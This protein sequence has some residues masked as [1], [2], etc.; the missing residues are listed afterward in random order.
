MSKFCE[1]TYEEA[2]IHLL[3]ENG[4]EYTCGDDLHRK[5]DET[6]IEDD[7]RDYLSRKYAAEALEDEEI[8]AI[9]ANLRNTGDTSDYLTLRKVFSLY[10]GRGDGFVF[11]RFDGNDTAL[12]IDYIDFETPENNTFRVVN[13]FTVT[14]KGGT[15]ERRPDVLLF[16]NGIPVCIV[17]LKNPAKVSATIEDAYDQIHIRYKRD[18]PHLMK[19]CALSCISDASNTRLGTTY[20]EYIHY[21]AW[22]KVENED[23][24]ANKGVPQLETLIKG[25]YRPDRL[26]QILRDFVY[27]PDVSSGREEEVVCRYPQFFATNLLSASIVKHLRSRG[28]DGKGGTYFGA[29]GCGKTYTMLFLSRY[30]ALREDS[31]GSPTIVILVDREDLQDQ[32]SKL[33]MR[34]AE[35]LSNGEVREIESRADLANELKVRESGGVFICTI[36]KF[37]EGT[38]LVNERSNIICFSDEAHRSQLGVGSKLQ[39][40]DETGGARSGATVVGE[41]KHVPNREIGAYV[42]YGFAKYLRDAFPN[43]TYVGFSG[44]PID[45]TIHVFG[46]IVDRY[47]MRQAVADDVTVGIKYIPRLARVILDKEKAKEIEYYYRLCADEGAKP[48][49]IADS[50]EAMASLEVI[51]SDEGRIKRLVN[52]I[53]EHYEAMCADNP[54]LIQK[55]MVVCASRPIA[56]QVYEEF[57]AIRPAWFKPEGYHDDGRVTD[58][59]KEKLK[60]MPFI[61]LVGT[62][63]KDDPQAMYEAFGDKKHR[64][65]LAEQFKLEHSNFRIAVVVDMWITG[66]DVPNLCVMYN[67]KPLQKQSLI[68]TI[69]RVNRKYQVSKEVKKEYGLIVDYI[70]IYENMREAMKKYGGDAEATSADEVET[71][72]AIFDAELS[73]LKEMMEGC[74]MSDFFGDDPLKRLLALQRGAEYVLAMPKIEGEKVSFQTRFKGH[75]RR[76]K[77][78]YDICHPAGALGKD[79]IEWAQMLLAIG[80]FIRKASD[81]EHD[82]ASM[83]RHVEQMV[84]EAIACTGV[85]SLLDTSKDAELIFSE[86]FEERLKEVKLPNTKFQMLVKMMKRAIRE[87]SMTNK[88]AAKRFDDML[89]EIVK[90]YNNRDSNVFANKVAGEVHEAVMK[91]VE[92]KV[93]SLSERIIE[94]FRELKTDKEKFK[95]LGITFEEKAFY[96]ILVSVR[97]DNGFEYANEKCL[98][99][100]K[101]IK[102]LIDD[103]AI[104]ADWKNN[105]NLRNQLNVDI[106]DLLYANGYPPEWH[107]KVYDRVMEQVDNFKRHESESDDG[108][109]GATALPDGGR[110]GARPSREILAAVAEALRFR[111]YLPVYTLRAAC[112]Y[113]GEGEPVEPEGWVKVENCGRLDEGMFVVRAKGRSMEP[114]IH[115]GDLCVMR[116]Y[117][118]GSRNGEIVLAQH[119]EFYDSDSG[120]AYSIKKYSSEKVMEEDGSW[121][122]ERITLSPLNRD[123]EPIVIDAN[124]D[125]EFAVVGVLKG[126]L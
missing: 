78:A 122:H 69:S 43:A 107:D 55:A 87:Y 83:N 117:E 45:E 109:R 36:Q 56:Y 15:K 79:N 68:Q 3:E 123:Y 71:A 47:T 51:L 4:W 14:Y 74:D 64:E 1:S 49:D 102:A 18:I 22:K 29:T 58:K 92:S 11:K 93:E 9:V 97:D 100:A 66:F 8:G 30:L 121:H 27:F 81:S 54:L 37:S 31:V 96:D 113:F 10:C 114:K 44:T 7:L 2:F 73:A 118:G 60:D 103:T 13:Q 120:G 72:K 119:R 12:P 32:T 59:E 24:A 67:D 90:E 85:E 62:Q 33:F 48:E 20:S 19:Y 50:K 110:A 112:G 23:P 57:R 99:L 53:A 82:T 76:L 40:V 17:E 63:G 124:E 115:D 75:L 104:Y 108:G 70:G 94:L 46:E 34:S 16:V 95:S 65:E 38:G 91:E 80:A 125:G 116:K 106:V 26:L 6:I 77:Q 105:A 126:V 88:I 41:Q 89:D 42:K 5:L 61:N 21:Y 84:K 86:D 25:A 39:I 35:Y 52:D 101:K 28:G 111:E 98:E